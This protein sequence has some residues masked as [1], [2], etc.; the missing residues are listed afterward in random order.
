MANN[1][2]PTPPNTPPFT[3]PDGAKLMNN[4][5][6]PADTDLLCEQSDAQTLIPA[7]QAAMARQGLSIA[8]VANAALN[9]VDGS[10]ENFITGPPNDP[11]CKVWLI[12]GVLTDGKANY[13]LNDYAGQIFYRLFRP[14]LAAGD[15]V[16]NPP[17]TLAIGLLALPP[18]PDG[19][20]GNWLAQGVYTQ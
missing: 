12:Q 9:V 4:P 14:N 11:N 6:P 2:T 10:A 3:Y 17:G 19:S 20:Q 5:L 16:S 7:Y 13:A 18:M 1:P 15:R 8:A